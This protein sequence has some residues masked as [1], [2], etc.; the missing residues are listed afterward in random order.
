MLSI[1]FKMVTVITININTIVI[2]AYKTPLLL[3]YWY[4]HVYFDN[5][6]NYNGDLAFSSNKLYMLIFIFLLD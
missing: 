4:I 3:L 1:L 5:D 2:H 6:L